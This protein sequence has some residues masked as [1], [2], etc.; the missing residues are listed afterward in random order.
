MAQRTVTPH[1]VDEEVSVIPPRPAV[2]HQSLGFFNTLDKP[3]LFITGLLLSIGVMMV[4]STTFDWSLQDY[5]NETTIM[6]MHVQNVLIGVAVMFIFARLDIRFVRRLAPLIMLSAVSFLVA[7]WLFGDDTFGAR[8]ALINGRFQPGEFSELAIIIYF[9]AWLGSKNTNVKSFT[10]G[11]IPFTVIISV[12]IGLAIL[13]PDL[14]VAVMMLLTGSS[15]FFLAGADTRQIG[16]ILVILVFT[17]LLSI[18]ILQQIAP[19]ALNRVDPWLASL[20]DLTQAHP[21]TMQ[22]AIAFS[23][24]GWTGVGLGESQAKFR[25]LPAPHTDSIF[26]VIGEELG[27]IGAC[28]VILLYVGLFLR[29]V[30][31]A[32]QSTSPFTIL[33]ASGLTIWIVAK[34]TLNIA[35]MTSLL[36]PAGLP[37]PFISYGGS[38]LVVLM[39][40]VGL[41][42]SVQRQNIYHQNSI[43]ERRNP[44]ANYDRSR[45]NRRTRLSR[46]SNSPSDTPEQA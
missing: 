43:T 42:L 21:H 26:A 40:G 13:Q 29:G 2:E 8:R 10:K 31:I 45:R 3:V 36:P 6:L 4:F 17:G 5:G 32:R 30:S 27:V 39:A 24:G 22:A 23:Y 37:L 14:S 9:S 19:Y 1:F 25:A 15:L 38:S 41:L 18:P 46:P 28:L 44:V 33:L 20:T 35:V 11:L 12:M 7:V 16:I 34:A